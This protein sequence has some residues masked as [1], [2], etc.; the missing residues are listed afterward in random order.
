MWTRYDEDNCIALCFPCHLY[1]WEKEKQ[2]EYMRFMRTRLGRNGYN[3]LEERAH[4]IKQ[5]RREDYEEV[6]ERYGEK[7]PKEAKAT[8]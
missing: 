3:R 8:V 6:I 1:K 5:W 4:V 7:E 2:G